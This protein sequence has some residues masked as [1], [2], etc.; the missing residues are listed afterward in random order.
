MFSTKY[1]Y[2]F[3]L[4]L[5]VYS[6]LNI[7]FTEGD[8]ALSTELGNGWL[9]SLVLILTVL[10]WEGNR[11]LQ[12]FSFEKVSKLLQKLL[13][14]FLASVLL[15]AVI[16]VLSS[17]IVGILLKTDI[18][19]PGFKQTLGFTFRI[20]LFLHCIN[21]IFQY[22]RA[23]SYSKI[24]AEKLKKQSTEAQLE[25]LRHQV[26]PHFLFNSLNVLS[27]VI[28]E[29]TKLGVKYVNELSKVYRYLLRSENEHLVDLTEEISFLES[30]TFLLKIRFQQNLNIR[31]QL[32][33]PKDQRIPPSTLQLLIENAIKHNEV[34]KA[35]PL[36]ISIIQ[37]NG[38]LIVENNIN[39]R[40]EKITSSGVGLENIK[41]RYTLLAS[42][43]PQVEKSEEQFI[44]RLPAIEKTQHE[45]PNN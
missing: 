4:L 12:N 20:N 42:E 40:N 2:I 19:L 39:L 13:Y 21:A 1:R 26:N 9:L 38:H 3:I 29:D 23:L 8:K 37:Q 5:G 30:Y 28:E 44:V 6:F 32:E 10:V 17:F 43:I 24:E 25:A 45:H 22:N 35:K 16:S 34:S 33:N 11:I 7:K 14:R 36:N 27:S 15:V 41:N 18:M 31:I